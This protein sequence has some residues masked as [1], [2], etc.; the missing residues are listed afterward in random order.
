MSGVKKKGFVMLPVILAAFIVGLIGVGLTS[1]YSGTFSTL[2]AGKAASQAQQ[3]ADVESNY[4]KLRGYDDAVGSVHDWKDT[5]DILGS[6]DGAKWQSKIEDTGR[7]DT[8]EDGKPVK[9][10][11]VSVRK[12]GE[13]I[14][15]YSQEI[16]L[17]QGLD[18]YSKDEID[19]MFNVVD[20][21]VSQLANNV[22]DIAK[23]IDIINQNI[24]NM[25]NNI[26]QMQSEINNIDKSI[27]AIQNNL[28]TLEK[29]IQAN[30]TKISQ[31]SAQIE[32]VK[33]SVNNLS[34][35]LNNEKAAREAAV[36]A[37]NTQISSIKG[38]LTDLNSKISSLNS[39]LNTESNERKA[40]ITKLS[41]DVQTK[42]AELKNLY[43]GLKGRLDG[44]EFVKSKD[45][46]NNIA[47]KYEQKDGESAKSLHAY[48][49]GVEVPL[50]SQGNDCNVVSGIPFMD[51]S[52][53]ELDYSTSPS[54][55]TT[56]GLKSHYVEYCIPIYLKYDNVLMRHTTLCIE[57]I[58]LRDNPY[59]YRVDVGY[60]NKLIYNKLPLID[61]AKGK[62]RHWTD[63]YTDHD[64]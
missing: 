5:T 35:N 7:D 26:N 12:T 63:N 20:K 11:K 15:R 32:Q 8:S 21:Q 14:S 27:S 33:K 39:Q 58:E 64:S 48:V 50:A 45:N 31:N 61:M 4:I 28:D 6:E 36:S 47:L 24:D 42:Y 44:N 53:G 22:N 3:I 62:M 51:V 18:V 23:S 57:K 55:K 46:A 38:S 29:M 52:L 13:I 10:M 34:Q 43:N 2:A 54:G 30:S 60:V 1:I 49:D 37:I 16:P 9:V 40:A 41:N 59:S 56:V 25:N 19:N 17:V